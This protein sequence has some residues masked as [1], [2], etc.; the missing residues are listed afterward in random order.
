MYHVTEE[1]PRGSWPHNI[2]VLR[3]PPAGAVCFPVAPRIIQTVYSFSLPSA[4]PYYLLPNVLCSVYKCL[5]PGGYFKVTII[6]PLPCAG[7]IGR[8]LRDWMEKHLFSNIERKS[9]C[10]EPS[11]LFPRLL[12]DAG[13]RGKGS[14]RTKVKF[15]ALQENA[16]GEG[17]NDPD[18]SINKLYQERRDKAELRSLAGRMLWVEVWGKHITPPNTWWWDDPECVA[19]CRQ[20]GTFWEYQIIDAFKEECV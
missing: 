10:L 2:H 20:L 13:L 11:R 8:K 18:R 19:E 15:F 4:C 17:Y 5:K 6:D 9:C 3:A 7:T 12:S 14:W 16:R 1:N